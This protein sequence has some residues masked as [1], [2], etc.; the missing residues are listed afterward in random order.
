MKKLEFGTAGIRGILGDGEIYL[1]ETHIIRVVDGFAKYLIENFEN[2]AQRGVVIGRDNRRQSK[3]FSQIASMVL[4]KYGII[5]HYNEEISATPFISYATRILNAVGAINITASHNPK[6]YNGVKLYDSEGCQLLPDAV[7]KMLSYFEE[8]DYFLEEK[9]LFELNNYIKFIPK[10]ILD[11]YLNEVVKIGGTI[12]DL[13]NIKV[14]YTPQHG[15]GAK[16]VKEI[17]EILNINAHFE[18]REMI[19]DTEFTYVNNPN[20]ESPESFNNVLKIAVENNCDIALVTDPDADRV[21]AAIRNNDN[22]YQIITGNETGILI[23]DYLLNKLSKEQIKNHY[24]IYSFVSSSLPKRIADIHG[25]KSYMTETGFKWIGNLVKKISENSPQKK[26]LF[27]FEESYGSLINEQ[28]CRDK[29]A[30]QSIV[31]LSKMASYYK[32]QG[33][34]LIDVLDNI[35]LKYGFVQSGTITLNINSYD[36][37]DKIKKSFKELNISDS[38]FLD[39]NQGIRSIEPNNMLTYEFDDGSWIS[40]RPSGTEPKIKIYLFFVNDIK[41]K[42]VNNYNKYFDILSKL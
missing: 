1:N 32:R 42:A 28:I 7:E 34:N 17:F 21:G 39:Y 2:A 10:K 22:K 36:H 6:E 14:A 16:P 30:I 33:F 41:E 38:L 3:N 29:D 31:I 15:T 4:S 40:L 20:P 8:Y 25:M 13:S 37:V 18:E 35:Y 24:L 11:S 19:E 27:A 12:N 9:I 23:F 26:F 5:V